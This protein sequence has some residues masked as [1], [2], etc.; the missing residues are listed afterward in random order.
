MSP[1]G[2]D[3]H[4]PSQNDLIKDAT[5]KEEEMKISDKQLV[6]LKS[7]F[8]KE[9]LSI[10]NSR[11]FSLVSIKAMYVIERLNDVFGIFGWGYEFTEPN[12]H[13]NEYVTKVTLIIY[14]EEHK[15]YHTIAQYGGKKIIKTNHTDAYKSSITDGLTKCASILGI[16]HTI[17]KGQSKL[18][19]E[20]SKPAPKVEDTTKPKPQGDLTEVLNFGKYK[21]Q[22]LLQIDEENPSYLPWLLEKGDMF[23]EGKNQELRD[24]I[25]QF[26]D[27]QRF[28]EIQDD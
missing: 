6:E 15:P 5:E 23:K 3:D 9:A 13:E 14:D 19:G 20:V 28:D 16:G 12:L 18:N 17:F 4:D 26:L 11:G 8:P 10:D 27:N 25:E 7:E 22:S 24:K 21:G 2:P 1:Y